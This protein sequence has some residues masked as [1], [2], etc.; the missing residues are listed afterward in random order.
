MPVF[1][2]VELAQLR[3]QHGADRDVDADAQRVVPLT[4]LSNPFC[5]RRSTSSRYF[6]SRPAWWMPTP[7]RRK[8]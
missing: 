8:R 1:S 5:A 2:P 6:G 4:T 7:W 3:E